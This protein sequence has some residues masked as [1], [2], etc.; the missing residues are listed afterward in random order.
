MEKDDVR[1]FSLDPR[2]VEK[3]SGFYI[4]LKSVLNKDSYLLANLAIEICS[5]IL[6]NLHLQILY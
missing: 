6:T 3:T 5:I 2:F 4:F 1:I